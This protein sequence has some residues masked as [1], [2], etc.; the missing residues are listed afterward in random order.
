MTKARD[1]AGNWG[2]SVTSTVVVST[3][4]PPT[5]TTTTVV[6]PTTVPATTTTTTTVPV[7]TTTVAAV[8]PGGPS[9]QSMPLG[10]L[11]GWRQIF[12]DDFTTDVPL[13]Q[14]PTAVKTSWGA[15]P[16]PWRDTSKKG[17]YSPDK[18]VSIDNGVLNKRLHVVNG[19]PLVAALTP[20]VPGTSKYGT[21]YGRYEVRFRTD[22]L[23]RGW[24]MAWLLW[25]DSGTNT[26]GSASGIGGNGE[27]NWPEK[28]L[29]SLNVWGFVHHQDATSGS[30]QK[31]FKAAA[32]IRVWHTY[33][34]EWSPNLVVLLL[35]GKEVGRTTERVPNTPMHWVLQTET[36]RYSELPTQDVNLEIDW[37]SVWEYAR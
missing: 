4:V 1:A 14:F 20:K 35:D 10:D 32:D 36:W 29:D 23:A 21:L 27:I 6:P 2:T 34:I 13:G 15:Y 25:P 3:T 22:R 7:T 31:W 16:S 30:D 5:T 9:G 11:P 8:R 18:V 12:R 26:T 28:N 24:K 37:V 17:L 19:Q 33:T